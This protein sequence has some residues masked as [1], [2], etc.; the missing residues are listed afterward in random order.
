MEDL[1]FGRTGQT[2]LVTGATGFVG[3]QLV[4][5]LLADGQKVVA[6]TRDRLAAQRR[7]GA[8]VRCVA[9][10]RELAA[11]ERIDVIVNLAGARILGPRWSEARKA[12]L[13]RSRIGLTQ[14]LVDWIA[15]AQHKPRVLLSASAIG[16]Y[17]IQE[18]G[19]SAALDEASPPQPIFMSQLCQEW[20]AAA[21]AAAAHGVQVACM[22]FGLVLGH[23]G[24]LPAMLLPV[25]MGVGG[26]MGSGRQRMSWLH[27]DDLLRAIAHLAQRSESASVQG[28]WNFTAP[29]CPTQL[30]FMQAAA[31]EAHRPCI[32]PTPGWPVRLLLGEQADLLL[33]GQN[34]APVRLLEEGFSFRYPAVQ[35]ALHSLM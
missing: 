35:G 15:K 34:V 21:Q 24:A 16:Y 19:S 11:D 12:E 27:L 14:G 28:A 20:E 32:M 10:M 5:A 26:R 22:R 30:E 29:E 1:H 6:L 2:F 4:R 23:G 25:K 13:R 7:L 8:M 17:G 3:T 31:R 33:E 9:G 18:Q